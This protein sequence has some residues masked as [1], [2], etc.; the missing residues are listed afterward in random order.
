MSEVVL[1]YPYFMPKRDTS[2]FRF[3]PLGIGYIASYLKEQKVDVKIIDCTF[4]KEDSVINY[5]IMSSP[6]IIGIYCMVGMENNALKLAKALRNHCKLLIAGGPHPT[7]FPQLFLNEF[8]I[9]V[10][11]EGEQTFFDILERFKNSKS[12][13]DIPGIAYKDRNNRII[14]TERRYI[15][16]LNILP[17]PLRSQYPNDE[18]IKYW[19]KRFVYSMSLLI[20]TRGCPF[21]CDYCSRPVSGKHYRERA[22]ESV[23]DEFEEILSLGYDRI[24]IADDAFTFRKK[25]VMEICQ[26]ILTRKIKCKWECLSRVDEMDIQMAQIMKESG[27]ERVFFGIESGN[28]SILKIMKKNITTEQAYNAVQCAKKA[29]LKIGAFFILGYPGENDYNILK[30]IEFSNSLDLDYISYSLPQPFPGTGLYEKVKDRLL[31]LKHNENNIKTKLTFRSNFSEHK[32]RFAIFKGKAQFK[33][34]KVL[35]QNLRIIYKIFSR[36]TDI[37]FKIMK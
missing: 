12:Y 24:W 5:T 27:C 36:I 34:K 17:P 20:T 29:G 26:E 11:G 22:K 16:D 14:K 18:Y 1:I 37:L 21:D 8:D 7:L 4:Q 10:L 30:T 28:N 15:K 19:K 35:P 32:L 31:P 13:F 23:V 25:Y 33:I 6:Q 2:S 9:V 3:P